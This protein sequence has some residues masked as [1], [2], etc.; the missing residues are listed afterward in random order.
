MWKTSGPHIQPYSNIGVSTNR[1]LQWVPEA[2]N[3]WPSHSPD[4]EIGVCPSPCHIHTT[5][6][7]VFPYTKPY[8]GPLK[9][10]TSCPHLQ[11]I[12]FSPCT[13]PY[14]KILK[15]STSGLYIQ[16][17]TKLVFTHTK[18]YNAPL[19]LRTSC[20]HIYPA[21]ILVFSHTKPYMSP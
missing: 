18:P 17:I 7:L 13:K 5:E 16:L 9:L 12:H 10:R 2:D 15:V 20:P 14:N 11:L 8:N 1:T 3:V 19:K 21:Q 6:R 4:S